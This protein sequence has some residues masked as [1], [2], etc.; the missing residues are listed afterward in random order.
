MILGDPAPAFVATQDALAL[1]ALARD[2]AASGS[3]RRALVVRLSRL[4][5]ELREPRHQRQLRDALAP[6]L[7][8]TR[9]RVYELP[10]G[11]VVAVAPPPGDHLDHARATLL[12]LLPDLPP[13]E[14]FPELRLPEQSAA[15][16]AAVED[17]LGLAAAAGPDG[18]E[19]EDG[20]AP[21]PAELD[22]AERALASADIS[23]FLRVSGLWRFGAEGATP[24]RLRGEIRVHLRDLAGALLP[25]FSLDASSEARRRFRAAAERR[26]LADLA[27]P[28]EARALGAVSLPLSLAAATSPEFLR[29][30]AALGAE[31]RKR[32]LVCLDPAD[33]FA[34]PSGVAT[35]LAFARLRGWALGLDDAEPDVFPLLRHGAFALARL[36]FR[37]SLLSG[38]AGAR[39]AL[40]AALPADRSAVLLSG[41]DGAAA[42]GWAWQRGISLLH[43]RVV[44]ARG[45]P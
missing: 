24:E 36:R 5:A 23:S 19:N 12:R 18:A 44:E 32:L 17:A 45:G 38:P 31:G 39:A 43:G 3:E 21:P 2:C 27:R 26:L 29:L 37:P 28:H 7:R 33:V 40:D 11:D 6:M 14:F 10:G 13:G 16:L 42:V 30:E 8:P 35:L 25:G 41:A 20:P 22:A 4:P 15:L 1:A 9:G 34:D